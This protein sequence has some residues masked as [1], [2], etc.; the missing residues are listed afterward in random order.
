MKKREW[1]EKAELLLQ[2]LCQRLR[3]KGTIG[4]AEQV[5]EHE[6][7]RIVVAALAAAYREGVSDGQAEGG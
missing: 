1:G 2:R 6:D 3:L 4:G 5:W 7:N